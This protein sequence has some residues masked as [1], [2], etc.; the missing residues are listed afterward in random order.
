MPERGYLV[1]EGQLDVEFI[2]RLLRL[3]GLEP[4]RLKSD[5]DPFWDV[6]V[7]TTFP[8]ADDL[9]RRVPVPRF[10][11]SASH[12]IAVHSAGSIT[13]LVQTYQEDFA[14]LP[15]GGVQ[16]VG[17]ILDADTQ[18]SPA[19]RFGAFRN[20]LAAL[21]D[22]PRLADGPGI[23]Q[24]GPPRS[25]VY[26]LPDNRS[27]GTLENLLLACGGVH[28]AGLLHDAQAFVDR[29]DRNG[30]NSDDLE[31]FRKPAGVNKAIVS[32]MASILK[33]AKSL[34]ISLH[35]NRWLDAQVVQSIPALQAFRQFIIEL[36]GLAG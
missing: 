10:L 35:D 15:A 20:E 22:A 5:L 9:L 27:A 16:G 23:I 7:P 25:G 34:Q 24:P 32:S 19:E 1:V 8:I 3:D 17:F 21:P 2:E 12:S 33:P 28:Y 36:L 11:Q 18:R 6:L 31:E 29:L 26:V 14:L 4:V 30:L 13:R